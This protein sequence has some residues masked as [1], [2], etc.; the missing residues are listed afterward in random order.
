M[1]AFIHDR[2]GR[3]RESEPQRTMQPKR[4][5]CFPCCPT[6]SIS[7]MRKAVKDGRYSPV[8][9]S[10]QPGVSRSPA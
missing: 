8:R 3:R 4:G 6:P 10:T 5:G 1:N 9:F 7:A 2:E